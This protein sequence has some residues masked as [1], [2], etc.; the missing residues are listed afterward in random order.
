MRTGAASAVGARRHN[1]N[2]ITMIIAGRRYG[3]WRHVAEGRTAL[4][5]GKTYIINLYSPS[6]GSK[7]NKTEHK[8]SKSEM[9]TSVDIIT[10]IM[11]QEL[12]VIT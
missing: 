6:S 9:S 7:N 1:E 8:Y 11:W 12:P 3:D 2:D 10:T 5:T 4:G